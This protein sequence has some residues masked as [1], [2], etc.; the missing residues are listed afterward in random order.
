MTLAYSY[1]RLRN[2]DGEPNGKAHRQEAIPAVNL[3]STDNV[4][5][6]PLSGGATPEPIKLY[7]RGQPDLVDPR[8]GDAGGNAEPAQAELLDE[9]ALVASAGLTKRING[10]DGHGIMPKSKDRPLVTATTIIRPDQP[11][12]HSYIASTGYISASNS[13]MPSPSI[14]R[15]S[16]TASSANTAHSALYNNIQPANTIPN[17]AGNG[18]TSANGQASSH[19]YHRLSLGYPQRSPLSSAA[20]SPDIASSPASQFS[21]EISTA[22]SPNINRVVSGTSSN[23]TTIPSSPRSRR[24]PVPPLNLPILSARELPPMHPFASAQSSPRDPSVKMSTSQTRSGSGV[25]GGAGREGS[26]TPTFPPGSARSLGRGISVG[27]SGSNHSSEPGT[28]G[29][30]EDKDLFFKPPKTS[31]MTATTPSIPVLGPVPPRRSPSARLGH[32]RVPSSSAS[33]S[34]VAAPQAAI[35]P[36]E[37]TTLAEVVKDEVERLQETEATSSDRRGTFHNGLNIHIP[38]PPAETTEQDVRRLSVGVV[39]NGTVEVAPP[40][41]VEALR[42]QSGVGSG[43]ATP[44]ARYEGSPAFDTPSPTNTSPFPPNHEY[45]NRSLP[46]LPAN[47][48][49]TSLGMFSILQTGPQNGSNGSPTLAGAERNDRMASVDSTMT[50][51]TSI[52]TPKDM[53]RSTTTLDM[54]SAL[55][56]G[57]DGRKYSATPLVGNQVYGAV[58]STPQLKAYSPSLQTTDD[59]GISGP[60]NR[61]R[62]KSGRLGFFSHSSS[63]KSRGIPQTSA[64]G[65][66]P[67]EDGEHDGGALSRQ[68]TKKGETESDDE[69]FSVS[70]PPSKRKMFEAGQTYIR[71]ERGNMIRF[72]DLFPVVN[73]DSEGEVPT[74]TKAELQ[75]QV[76]GEIWKRRG[77]LSSLPS[78]LHERDGSGTPTSA[79]TP[80]QAPSA[81]PGMRSIP[82]NIA[83]P[84]SSSRPSTMSN[85]RESGT[86]SRNVSGVSGASASPFA[87]NLTASN[88]STSPYNTTHTITTQDIDLRTDRPQPKTVVFFI[89]TFYCGQCQDYTLASIAHI[90][91]EALKRHNIRLVVISNGNWRHIK[92]YRELF[93]CPYPIYVDASRKLYRHMG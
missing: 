46:S 47:A 20:S 61:S 3:N 5:L 56:S 54:F 58:G 83:T 10:S 8:T 44:R 57:P 72:A 75:A 84:P 13:S 91:P 40:Q 2:E 24:K 79:T 19:A 12:P 86:Y 73:G 65:S 25:S 29:F 45:L 41:E 9:D 68:R 89:R 52:A 31:P 21:S 69:G 37:Q 35:N 39:G 36:A 26:S 27:G 51:L 93:K 76:E 50:G 55:E 16:S 59:K 80:T 78:I 87:F 43:P 7:N 6:V 17:G 67:E 48:S 22:S 90:D 30:M 34:P 15:H 71:D 38:A 66:I 63:R 18:S 77:S 28:P 32:G 53:G 88:G 82:S 81:V 85:G 23:G 70:R 1:D 92:P 60:N 64:P 42:R 49:K 14:S 11:R 33:S 74:I 4:S 62:K